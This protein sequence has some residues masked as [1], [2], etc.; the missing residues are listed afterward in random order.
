MCEGD[1]EVMQ[2][3]SQCKFKQAKAILGKVLARFDEGT[4]DPDKPMVKNALVQLTDDELEQARA[5]CQ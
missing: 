4:L 5:I 2:S 1:F 3:G